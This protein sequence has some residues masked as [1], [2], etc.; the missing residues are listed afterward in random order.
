MGTQRIGIANRPPD[1]FFGSGVILQDSPPSPQKRAIALNLTLPPKNNVLIL[2]SVI[3][4]FA[5]SRSRSPLPF[6]SSIP[7]TPC[8]V[9]QS[10]GRYVDKILILLELKV[11]ELSIFIFGGCGVA[12]PSK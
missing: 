5:Q 8:G 1:K 3:H 10:P 7:S 9:P 11:P 4:S 6:H 2:I 12:P